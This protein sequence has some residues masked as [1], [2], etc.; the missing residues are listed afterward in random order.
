VG[1]ESVIVNETSHAVGRRFA[2]RVAIVTGGTAGIG[3]ATAAELCREGASA[4]VTGLAQDGDAPA[5]LAPWSD[6]VVCLL[7]DM[8]DDSFCREVVETAQARFGRV[9]CLVNNA[10]SFLAKSLD[11]TRDDF[12]YSMERGPIAY[13]RM[14]QFA[15]EAMHRT[16]G[17]SIVNVSSISG[18]VAQRN[19]WT[20]N[21]AKGA[22]N[23]ITRCAAL[24]LAQLGIRVNSVSPGWIETRE[25]VKAAGD[26]WPTLSRVWGDYHMLRRLG[27]TTE[28]AKAILFL[29]SDDASFITGVDLPVDGGYLSMGP[30]GLGET[31]KV[32]GSR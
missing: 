11:A 28:C 15:G 26:E 17:G 1:K 20:Y 25:V 18:W 4:V 14:I 12:V 8:G 24:D 10:F 13:A 3:L 31:A 5:E 29:L 2:G 16:G 22:V 6:R 7:G 9:D 32:A 21:A 23:Q 19:R 27:T 30:E